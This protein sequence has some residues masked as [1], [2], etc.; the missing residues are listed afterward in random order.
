VS[1]R[2]RY[3]ALSAIRARLLEQVPRI[4]EDDPVERDLSERRLRAAGQLT[5]M[6]EAL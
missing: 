6:M 5:R 4:P 1:R 3:S 2:R